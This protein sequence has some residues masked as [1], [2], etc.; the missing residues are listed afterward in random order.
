[1]HGT[2]PDY[3][4]Y[5]VHSDGRVEKVEDYYAGV[6]IRC[7][8]SYIEDTYLHDSAEGERYIAVDPVTGKIMCQ[9]TVE[10]Y[11]RLVQA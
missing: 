5:R 11:K 9:F 7:A 3:F 2:R 1:M 6:S 4:I 10:T 8:Q